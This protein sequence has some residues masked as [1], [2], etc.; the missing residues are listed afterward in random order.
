MSGMIEH[1]KPVGDVPGYSVSDLGRVRNDRTGRILK[2]FPRGYDN[3]Y[4]GVDLYHN[5]R[6]I[7]KLAH[8][9]VAAAFLPADPNPARIEVN[10]YDCDTLNNHFSNL[11]W[12]TRSENEMHKHFME[13]AT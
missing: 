5:R 11:E 4:A 8:R 12:V 6:R 7:P 2:Q 9:L 3:L 10:H 1:W 13:I